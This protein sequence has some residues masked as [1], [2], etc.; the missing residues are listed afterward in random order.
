MGHPFLFDPEDD[1]PDF[2]AEMF[3]QAEIRHGETVIRPY[4]GPGRP[5]VDKLKALVT[6]RLDTD[7]LARLRETGLEWQSR[8]NEAIRAWVDLSVLPAAKW[9]LH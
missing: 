1:A 2:T 7:L 8:L 5:K 3:E 4:C 6:L 9:Q